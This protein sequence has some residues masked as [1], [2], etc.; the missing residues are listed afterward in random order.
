MNDIR[1]GRPSASSM[2]RL[3]ACAAS[4]NLEKQAP[5]E[6]ENPDATS[7]TRIHAVL[8]GIAPYD[9][10]TL[11]EQDTVDMCVRDRDNLLAEWA[12]LDS[13]VENLELRLGL[14][15]F[16]QVIEVTESTP[17]SLLVYTGQADLIAWDGK[18]AFVIDY[19]TS[20]GDY[21]DAIDNAQLAALAVLVAG[22]HHV[23]EVRVAIVQPWAGKPTVSTYLRDSLTTARGWIGDVCAQAEKATPEMATPGAHC[24]WCKAKVICEAFKAKMLNQIEVVDPMSIAGLP[25]REQGQAMFARSMELTPERHI[26]AYRSLDMIKRFVH[27]I[28]STFR[29]RVEAGE[30]PGWTV[31]TKEGAR[32]ITYPQKAFA[33]LEPLGITVDD[34]LAASSVAIG[35][36]EEALRKASGIKS[37]SEG[38]TAYNL[39]A[40][41]A[42]E[43]L[44]A[45]LSAA[46]ALGR[47][48][49]KKELKHTT[50]LEEY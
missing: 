43:S 25:A 32:E 20:R 4:W 18:R 15:T 2:D 6:P 13:Y 9:S 48:A 40:K 38:R 26:A 50:Q 7:G 17:P 1:K 49:E 3:S 27:A 47:K 16:G 39:T 44:T 21:A 31:E 5:A 35:P 12:G 37:Q 8:A 36:L 24:K 33:A 10:L 28:D 14:T 22:H 41:A 30:I 42:K 11:A 46:N 29:L 19:K 45:A 23:D 34:F